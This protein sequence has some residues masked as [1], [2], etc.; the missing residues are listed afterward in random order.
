MLKKYSYMTHNDSKIFDLDFSIKLS[1]S[2]TPENINIL[3]VSYD[4]YILNI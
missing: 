1:I 3:S 2:S 4:E